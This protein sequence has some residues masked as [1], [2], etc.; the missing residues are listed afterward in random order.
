[1]EDCMLS[2]VYMDW[3]KMNFVMNLP[4]VGRQY[5]INCLEDFCTAYLKPRG[6]LGSILNLFHGLEVR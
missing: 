1:M 4:D 2:V 5:S 3:T 6:G